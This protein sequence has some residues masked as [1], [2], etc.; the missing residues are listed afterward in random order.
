[1]S[2]VGTRARRCSRIQAAAQPDEQGR[3]VV[4][5]NGWTGAGGGRPRTFEPPRTHLLPWYRGSEPRARTGYASGRC[6]WSTARLASCPRCTRSERTRHAARRQDAEG[7]IVKKDW[8]SC[9]GRRAPTFSCV[10]DSAWCTVLV[11]V[12]ALAFQRR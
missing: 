5:R 11:R 2:S 1:V 10:W 4:S 9:R 3:T 12:P 8:R 6:R 7:S